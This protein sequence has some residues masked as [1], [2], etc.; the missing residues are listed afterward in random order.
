MAPIR[1]V[2]SEAVRRGKQGAEEVRKVGKDAAKA[3]ARAGARAAAAVIAVAVIDRLKHSRTVKAKKS[4]RRKTIAAAVAG[5]AA[6]TAAGI[7][8]A[9]SRRKK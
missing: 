5:A 2:A 9:R 6:L 4:A 7:A 8:V 1:K 3:G